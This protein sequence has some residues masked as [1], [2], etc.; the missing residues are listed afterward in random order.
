M[1]P[2][3]RSEGER[4]RNVILVFLQYVADVP[5]RFTKHVEKWCGWFKRHLLYVSWQARLPKMDLTTHESFCI[6]SPSARQMS[7]HQLD[8]VKCS[9]S[10]VFNARR[11]WLYPPTRS[12]KSGLRK[13]RRKK[14]KRFPKKLYL[15]WKVG[16]LSGLPAQGAIVFFC[17]QSPHPISLLLCRWPKAHHSCF[18]PLRSRTFTV[19]SLLHKHHL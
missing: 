7:M 1:R 2:V 19:T 4:S 9:L 18:E 17:P 15:R 5:R 13:E 16:R 3:E 6:L 14:E 10:K 11:W 12:S 8:D